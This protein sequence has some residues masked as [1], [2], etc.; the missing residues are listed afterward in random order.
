MGAKFDQSEAIDNR[1]DLRNKELPDTGARDRMR[2]I[3]ETVEQLERSQLPSSGGFV[4]FFD[5]NGDLS[6]IDQ[7]GRFNPDLLPISHRQAGSE[8]SYSEATRAAPAKTSTERSPNNDQS[9]AEACGA[10]V[11]R[12]A[13]EK[14][15]REEV[16]AF[17]GEVEQLCNNLGDTRD[18]EFRRLTGQYLRDNYSPTQSGRLREEIID[19]LEYQLSKEQDPEDRS[20]SFRPLEMNVADLQGLLER[21]MQNEMQFLRQ[22]NQERINAGKAPLR[23]PETDDPFVIAKTIRKFDAVR[24]RDIARAFRD[25][26]SI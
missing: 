2:V 6:R 10:L 23:L 9:L 26:E 21:T 20:V 17:S 7:V 19:M 22:E 24:S 4:A 3:T 5:G 14:A 11:Y 1:V 8:T 13:E 16:G 25:I 12:T 18:S 15:E